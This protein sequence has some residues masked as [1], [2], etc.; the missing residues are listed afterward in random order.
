[1]NKKP[2]RLKSVNSL[3][4]Q[5][6]NKGAGFTLIETLIYLG[7]FAII[8]SGIVVSF[9]T[10][11]ESADRTQG[12]VLIQEEGSFLLAKMNWAMTG[13]TVVSAPTSG[14]SGNT[15]TLTK[16]GDTIS[17]SLSGT[18]LQMQRGSSPP[19]VLNSSDVRVSTTSSIFTHTGSGSSPELV[20]ANF[21]LSA[22]TADGK[23]INQDFS[24]TKYL[25]K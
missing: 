13:A 23:V 20:T 9:Y 3:T 5:L 15:L 8:M 12:R 16:A 17:F 7:L 2:V 25:R 24:T 18:D 11:F 19:V 10:V 22:N 14:N 21:T 4:Q 1:M 6:I